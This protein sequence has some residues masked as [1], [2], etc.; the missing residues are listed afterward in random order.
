MN[1]GD[2]KKHICNSYTY[3]NQAKYDGQHFYFSHENLKPETRYTYFNF[4][5][6]AKYDDY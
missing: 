6:I 4:P 3:T 1:Y 2:G 5:I